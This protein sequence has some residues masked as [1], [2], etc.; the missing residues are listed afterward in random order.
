MMVVALKF[1]GNTWHSCELKIS[2]IEQLVLHIGH[3][4][5]YY[6][7]SVYLVSDCRIFDIQSWGYSKT[8]I[9]RP[10]RGD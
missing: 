3:H 1:K 7:Y 4:S 5:D 2:N 6:R 8:D 9:K 10:R